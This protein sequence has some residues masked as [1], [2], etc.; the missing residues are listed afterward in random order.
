MLGRIHAVPVDDAL[1]QAP[2]LWKR[3]RSGKGLGK[4]LA[5]AVSGSVRAGM[6]GRF[7]AL[8]LRTLGRVVRTARWYSGREPAQDTA[9]IVH[10]DYGVQNLSFGS[11]GVRAV[12]D[13]EYARVSHPLFDLATALAKFSGGRPEDIDP[14]VA[15]LVLT[16]YFASRP[17]MDG[18]PTELTDFLGAHL[19]LEVL[20]AMDLM[21]RN[22]R[23]ATEACAVLLRAHRSIEWL[24]RHDSRLVRM[25]QR[26][27]RDA[28]RDA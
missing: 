21:A 2:P 7:P 3:I 27:E 9:C 11:V 12:Y 25:L 13:W 15:R 23:K 17:P 18:M 26:A 14:R 16:G 8:V 4:L 1:R 6:P 28:R 22:P 5:R 19:A 24:R 10:G 20:F